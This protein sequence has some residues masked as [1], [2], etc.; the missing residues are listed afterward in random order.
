MSVQ[1][2]TLAGMSSSIKIQQADSSKCRATD[3][4]SDRR[5]RTVLEGSESREECSEVRVQPGFI[6][7]RFAPSLVCLASPI[8]SRTYLEC[9][10]GTT[11]LEPATSAVTGQRSNQLSYV[12]RKDLGTCCAQRLLHFKLPD[13]LGCKHPVR[14]TIECIR[15]RAST[16]R[17]WR[18][19]L[20]QFRTRESGQQFK[21]LPHATGNVSRGEACKNPLMRSRPQPDGCCA[22]R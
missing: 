2:N 8:P 15:K 3:D 20:A 10:A 5:I 22:A 14:N 13:R 19:R 21:R 1:S 7:T 18:F 17:C 12:P 4:R 16:A 9:M 6:C 11:G